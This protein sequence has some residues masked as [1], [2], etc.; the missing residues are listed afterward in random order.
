MGDVEDA[1]VETDREQCRPHAQGRGIGRRRPAQRAVGRGEGISQ[2]GRGCVL[3]AG[4]AQPVHDDA[5][6]ERAGE[7]AAGVAAHAVGDQ[8]EAGPGPRHERVLVAAAHAAGVGQAGQF[9]GGGFGHD[10]C[11]VADPGRVVHSR[12][13]GR[14]RVGAMPP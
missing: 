13:P 1:G 11:G 12:P 7:V 14:W 5:Q 4:G 6:R 2:R 8:G 3:R 10:G 9:D